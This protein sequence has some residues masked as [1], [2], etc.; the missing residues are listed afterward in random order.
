MF[1]HI[2]VGCDGSPEGRD[3]VALGAALASGCDARLSLVG[4]FPITLF[5]APGVTDRRT[6]R[7]Q[8]M[9]VLRSERDLI[10]PAPLI[11]AVADNSV[12]RALRH[13]AERHHAD[14][15]V[16]GSAPE[17]PRGQ[18]LI[19]RRGR[20]LLSDAPFSLALAARGL[21]E[22]K[23]G[24]ASIGV[25]YDA[26]REGRAALT[27]A[28]GYARASRARLRVRIVVEDWIPRLT[29]EEAVQAERWTGV[30]EG[31]RRK[32][33]A[34]AESAVRKLGVE[35]EVSATIGDP[36]DQL[37]ELSKHVD[38]LV[39]GSRR[40]GAVARLWTGGVGE[41]LVAGSSCSLVIVPRPLDPGSRQ[42]S[43]ADGHTRQRMA[44]SQRV[45][46]PVTH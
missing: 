25:G 2:V 33:L 10:T 15:V 20:Q 44:N 42:E 36:A 32:A 5:P 27:W 41:T 16:L 12:P 37:R 19:G 46:D 38:L 3:A 29:I 39:V 14:L 45:G 4:V 31:A 13:Y 40:W 6:L 18:I 22:A 11:H 24:L 28:S 1:R 23:H 21:R 26:S 17:A 30:W 34:D 9:Q 8:T 35:A 43:T 7:S